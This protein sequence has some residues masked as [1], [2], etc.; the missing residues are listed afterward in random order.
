MT[1]V[2]TTV[3]ALDSGTAFRVHNGLG[4]PATGLMFAMMDGVRDGRL[5]GS[6]NEAS[7]DA[8]CPGAELLDILTRMR[9]VG[10][11]SEGPW[12]VGRAYV[13]VD[14]AI[15]SIDPEQSHRVCSLEV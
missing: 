4:G 7:A 11:P 14:E 9:D 5:S 1:T 2:D 12:Q 13:S 10:G 15:A 8:I 3:S 6:F